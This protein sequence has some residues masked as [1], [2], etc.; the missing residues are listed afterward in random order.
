[1]RFHYLVKHTSSPLTF[2][3]ML[4]NLKDHVKTKTI[5]KLYDMVYMCKFYTCDKSDI[6]TS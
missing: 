2:P 3:D 5:K 4:P 6:G 1:M